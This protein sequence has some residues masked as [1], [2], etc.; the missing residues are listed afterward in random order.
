MGAERR[1]HFD[2]LSPGIPPPSPHRKGRAIAY[3]VLKRWRCATSPASGGGKLR[4][5]HS[6]AIAL[7]ARGRG[8]EG[9]SRRHPIQT[10]FIRAPGD[11][12]SALPAEMAL[13]SP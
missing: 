4:E 11:R 8:D 9:A 13:T 10:G 5:R 6:Y 12:A 3:G 1:T 7:T 2:E